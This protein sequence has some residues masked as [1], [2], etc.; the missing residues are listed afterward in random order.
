MASV[1]SALIRAGHTTET[2]ASNDDAILEILERLTPEIVIL[3]GSTTDR[4]P[5]E[6]RKLLATECNLQEVLLVFVTTEDSASKI[7]LSGIDDFLIAPYTP[8]HVVAR[9]RLIL[10]RTKNIDGD[11]AVKVGRLVI[12]LGN[13]EITLDGVPIEMTFKEYELLKFL[14]THQGRVFTREA[15][16][17]HVWGYDYY[18]GTRTVDVHVRRIRSKLGTESENL[19]ETVRNVGYRFAG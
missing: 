14:A 16:L 5:S 18:G 4:Q 3:D 9:I 13:Y 19:I 11:Q 1:A 7:E 6:I 15:L 12:D 10:W 2:C 17:D 8:G